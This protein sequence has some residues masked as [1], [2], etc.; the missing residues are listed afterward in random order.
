MPAALSGVVLV[1][2]FAAIAVLAGF[3]GVTA[4]RRAGS[5]EVT[6]SHDQHLS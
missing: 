4:F 1:A 5:R 2:V 3:L 6:Q